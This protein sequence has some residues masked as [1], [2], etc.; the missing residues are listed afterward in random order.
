MERSPPTAGT[1]RF[2]HW[3]LRREERA[4]LVRGQ[5]VK[6]GSR[7]FDV[8][9]ALV[10]RRGRVVGK[11]ELLDLAWPGLIVEENNLSVQISALR[12][13][14]GAD[15]IVNVA[16]QGYQLAAAR[17]DPREPATGGSPAIQPQLFG[18]ERE[19]PALLEL[20]GMKPLVSIVGP[21]GVGKTTIAKWVVASSEASWPDGTHWIDLSAVSDGVQLGQAV[22]KSLGI[23]TGDAEQRNE[24]LARAL[25]PLRALIALDNC[26]HLLEDAVAFLAP[27]LKRAPGV[28]WLATSREPLHCADESVYRLGP[29]D[30]PPAAVS[31]EQAAAYGALA[32]LHERAQSGDRTFAIT[33]ANVDVCIELCRQLDGL[34]LAIE[35]AAARVATLG[36]QGVHDQIGQ[37]LR[38]P[39]STRGA[40]LRHHTLLETYEWSYSLLSDKEQIVFRRLEPFAGGFTAQLAQNLCSAEA[41]EGEQLAGWEVLDAL[42]ALIDKSL[43]QRS[44][45]ATATAGERLHL[46]E[47]ARDYARVKLQAR[48]ELQAARRLHAYVIAEWFASAQQDLQRWRDKD[49]ADKYV[50]ERRNVGVAL[51]WAC[52]SDDADLL[53]TL[54]AAMARLDSFVHVNAEI[55]R[56]ALP[57]AV[58]E[59]ATVPLRGRAYLELG[60]A[61]FLD[62]NRELG[63]D[64]CLRALS[65]FRSLGDAE[66]VYSSLTRLIRLYIGRPG[67]EEMARQ[68]WAQLKEIDQSSVSLRARLTCHSTVALLFEGG[69]TVER[70]EELNRIAQRSGLEAH[71]AVCRLNITDELLLQDRF[72]E[73][74]AKTDEMLQAGEPMLRVRAIMHHNRAHALVRLGRIEEARQSEQIMLRALPGYA[75]LALDLF[76]L[77]A[78]QQG[79]PE[80]AALMAGCSTRMKR[81]RDLDQDASEA[82]L[83][84]ETRERLEKELGPE[85]TA[86]LM[87]EGAAMSTSDA[88]A[89]AWAGAA[90]R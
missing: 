36:L 62:G 57:M 33:D 78:L 43:V 19:L 3:E 77:V 60:W 86:N 34:P 13:L 25:A 75:H 44:L 9:L 61:H 83:I 85:R 46:L 52:T 32:L 16:G 68:I 8:L 80:D 70:L 37:R 81:E 55:V 23:F 58:L 15:A 51:T 28:R 89:L 54:V 88:L 12:K 1:Y 6:L 38:L 31:A 41:G 47:S 21:G 73:V 40:P 50:P 66:G 72:E 4:L 42:S 65:D 18:R 27:L 71:G 49:W 22:S 35:M 87:R 26:E 2:P 82:T 64:L 20:V 11:G 5:R 17:D 63:T 56:F 76:S 39:L 74:V 53:A 7:A 14:L 30:V 59:R 29:L 10:E 45:S 48:L 90:S 67:M 79:R 69:R 24:D 84:M